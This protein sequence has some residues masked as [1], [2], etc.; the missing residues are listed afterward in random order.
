MRA[1]ILALVVG[2]FVT[3][4]AGS[5]Q[6]PAAGGQAPADLTRL[7]QELRQARRAFTE[8]GDF[9]ARAIDGQKA[10][11]AGQTK[12]SVPMHEFMV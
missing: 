11:L 1:V 7:A 6:P 4:S 8:A 12:L 2:S 5:G 9:S 3:A 10:Q